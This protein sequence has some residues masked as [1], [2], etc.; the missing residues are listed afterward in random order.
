GEGAARLMPRLRDHITAVALRV[1]VANVSA[2]DIVLE[3][4]RHTSAEEVNR[5]LE[6]AAEVALKDVVG[7]ERAPL[8]SRDFNHDPRSAIIDGSSTTVI[9]GNMVRLL[10]WFDNEWAY[11]ARLLDTALQMVNQYC[12]EAQRHGEKILL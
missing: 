4:C 11:A 6:E 3:T 2:L 1:P 12:P 5:V 9:G 10:A 7:M 8:V